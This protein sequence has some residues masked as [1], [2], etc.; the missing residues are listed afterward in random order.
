M[1]A[2]WRDAI[3]K[4]IIM[5]TQRDLDDRGT[6]NP[7]PKTKIDGFWQQFSEAKV[8]V[9]FAS[10]VEVYVSVVEPELLFYEPADCGDSD[11]EKSA[12]QL[13]LLDK[14]QKLVVHE[15]V[16]IK[17]QK[18]FLFWGKMVEKTKRHIFGGYVDWRSTISE[19]MENLE[20]SAAD[21]KFILSYYEHTCAAIMYKVP[22]NF[23]LIQMKEKHQQDFIRQT[24]EARAAF[25]QICDGN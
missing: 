24:E 5:I 16:T 9:G 21:V 20:E 17:S 25:Q 18:C 13:F 6:F 23:S 14:D 1:F 10:V 3:E 15:K 2:P 8:Y 4:E 7:M 22:E 11:C 19:I 12:E